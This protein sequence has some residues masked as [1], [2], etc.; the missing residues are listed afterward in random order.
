MVSSLHFNF[1]DNE[2]FHRCLVTVQNED[3]LYPFSFFENN[4]YINSGFHRCMLI[5]ILNPI[6]SN[7]IKLIEIHFVKP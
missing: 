6:S 3:K 1:N 5:Q 4:L 7:L 2:F